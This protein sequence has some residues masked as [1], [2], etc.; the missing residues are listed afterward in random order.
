M[1][2]VTTTHTSYSTE[3]EHRNVVIAD[4]QLSL[5]EFN[6][7]FRDPQLYLGLLYPVNCYFIND[8][9]RTVSPPIVRTFSLS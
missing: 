8:K 6:N 7:F 1:N 5:Y 4:V 3:Q 2:F 9:E